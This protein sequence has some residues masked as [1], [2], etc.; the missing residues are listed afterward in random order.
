MGAQTTCGERPGH[1]GPLRRG[2][3]DAQLWPLAHAE[4]LCQYGPCRGSR[5]S[6]WRWVSMALSA[7]EGSLKCGRHLQPRHL[8]APSKNLNGHPGGR[9][10][11]VEGRPRAG[12]CGRSSWLVLTGVLNMRS[13]AAAGIGAALC[14]LLLFFWAAPGPAVDRG[15]RHGLTAD[16]CSMSRSIALT[17]DKARRSIAG[18]AVLD[19][20]S[21]SSTTGR[22]ARWF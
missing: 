5:R 19:H 7:A 1:F 6:Y 18:G 4:G 13:R 15:H 3:M 11:V 20:F 22:W 17:A 14:T 9:R 21:S 10:S 8:G 12:R 2:E 16:P